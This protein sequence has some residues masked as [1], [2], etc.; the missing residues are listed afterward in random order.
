MNKLFDPA[1]AGLR[2]YDL[3]DVERFKD[4]FKTHRANRGDARNSRKRHYETC[5]EGEIT[6]SFLTSVKAII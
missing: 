5:G 6:P 4:A 1:S 3:E 2:S